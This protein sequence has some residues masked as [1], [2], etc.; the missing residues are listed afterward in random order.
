M[1]ASLW[2]RPPRRLPLLFL[3]IAVAPAVALAWLGWRLLEQDRALEAQHIHERLENAADLAGVQLRQAQAEIE[4]ALAGVA[5]LPAQEVAAALSQ[6]AEHLGEGAVLVVFEPDR[7]ESYPNDRLL[8][9][10]Y[11]PSVKEAP[12]GAFAKGEELEFQK[13][14]YEAAAAAYRRLAASKDS[15]IRAGALLRLARTLRKAHRFE[16]ALG[17]YREL[18]KLGRVRVDELPAELVARHSACGLLEELHRLEEL[19]REAASL[20]RDLG[21][22]RWKISRAAYHFRSSGI[23]VGSSHCSAGPAILPDIAPQSGST[24]NPPNTPAPVEF[25]RAGRSTQGR[26]DIP[27]PSYQMRFGQP[28]GAVQGARS[29]RGE[30]NP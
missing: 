23:L 5:S 3:A 27:F 4:E 12:E 14:G 28:P 30:A 20:Y 10:P 29:L 7:V 11:L 13:R 17:T 8:Y 26:C 25:L 16:E 19:R 6:R 9:Y 21:R 2:F 1:P 22:G 18:E 15:A 24:E